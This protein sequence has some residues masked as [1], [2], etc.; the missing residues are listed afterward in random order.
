MKAESR[1]SV[2]EHTTMCLAPQQLTRDELVHD[3]KFVH[4]FLC[5]V[6]VTGENVIRTVTVSDG[7]M[8]RS[9]SKRTSKRVFNDVKHYHDKNYDED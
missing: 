5:H 6:N 7:R 3:T 2:L 4:H 8:K 1:K 9:V